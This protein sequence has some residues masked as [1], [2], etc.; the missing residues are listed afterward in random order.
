MEIEID[1]AQGTL[2]ISLTKDNRDLLVQRNAVSQM[3][4]TVLVRFDGFF[5]QR[6]QGG[7]AF[8]R[9]FIQAYDEFIVGLHGI[10]DFLFESLGFHACNLKAAPEN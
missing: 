5:Y 9:S 3:G 7:L 8:F 2:V 6:F 1:S 4:A 10:S